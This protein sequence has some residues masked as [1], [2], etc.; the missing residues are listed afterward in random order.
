MGNIRKRQAAKRRAAAPVT[1]VE[2][3]KLSGRYVKP[4]QAPR[5]VCV[6]VES[7]NDAAMRVLPE[8]P[9]GWKLD[10]IVR[11]DHSEGSEPLDAPDAG[12]EG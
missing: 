5:W 2:L 6:E 3:V 7:E 8:P 9:E 10:A 4:G 11:G 12:T 1:V